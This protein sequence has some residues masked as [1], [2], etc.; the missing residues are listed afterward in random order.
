MRH[1]LAHAR[2]SAAWRNYTYQQYNVLRL[3]HA[4]SPLVQAEVARRLMVSPPVVTRLVG[5]L[6][7]L[8]FV[9][10][11][12]D[13]DDRRASLLILTPAGRRTATRMRRGFL[14]A[15]SGLTES[16]PTERRVAIASALEELQILLPGRH[17][18]DPPG[19]SATSGTPRGGRPGGRAAGTG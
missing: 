1:L 2:R 13:P 10:R 7:D 16:L 12:P 18:A 11:R 3:I 9:E 6:V 15:A 5:S 17:A 19:R 4:E 8:G 14:G